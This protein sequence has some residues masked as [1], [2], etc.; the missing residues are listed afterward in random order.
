MLQ[1]VRSLFSVVDILS[2]YPNET[3]DCSE[4]APLKKALACENMNIIII[5]CKYV[6]SFLC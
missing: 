1:H 2:Y 6:F 3:T 5:V 4:N